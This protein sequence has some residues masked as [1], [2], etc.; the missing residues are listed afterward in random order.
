MLTQAEAKRR[1]LNKW[2]RW[3]EEGKLGDNPDGNDA[4]FK[5]FLPLEGQNDPVLNFRC[6]EDKWQRIHGWLIQGERVR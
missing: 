5:F 6:R 3:A 1:V 2:D 4:F